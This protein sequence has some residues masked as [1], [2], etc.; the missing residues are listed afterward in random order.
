MGDAWIAS[1]TALTTASISFPLASSSS[2]ALSPFI[3]KQTATIFCQILLSIL[4]HR[5]VQLLI[6]SFFPFLFLLGLIQVSAP[7]TDVVVAVDSR[8]S[9]ACSLL[10]AWCFRSSLDVAAVDSPVPTV[11]SLPEASVLQRSC[12]CLRFSRVSRD[13]SLPEASF[14]Q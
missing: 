14:L 13:S 7:H 10:E 3:T 8:V 12:R 5:E 6:A 1:I 9:R 2:S 11:C 4:S